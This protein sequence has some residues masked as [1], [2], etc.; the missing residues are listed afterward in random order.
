MGG[1]WD[2]G[3]QRFPQ[4]KK[5]AGEPRVPLCH[6]SPTVTRGGPPPRPPLSYATF[7]RSEVTIFLA[8]IKHS[9]LALGVRTTFSCGVAVMQSFN[10]GIHEHRRANSGNWRDH[11]DTKEVAVKDLFR[12]ASD[13][14]EKELTNTM[15]GNE[16]ILQCN[17]FANP[18]V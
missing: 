15:H 1:G 2:A 7:R 14:V 6:P 10:R 12:P 17:A 9:L 5:F 16:Y 18:D 11:T 8:V 4:L 13:I 3:R